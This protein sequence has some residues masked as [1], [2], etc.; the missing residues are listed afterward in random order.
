MKKKRRDILIQI[1][2]SNH[3]VYLLVTLSLLVILAIGVYATTPTNSQDV[4]NATF[5][6]T[7]EEISGISEFLYLNYSTE[8]VKTG[9]TWIDGKPIY[10]KVV[11][12]GNLPASGHK[13]VAHNIAN[14][15]FFLPSSSFA[16]GNGGSFRIGS[17]WSY[18]TNYVYW[19]LTSTEIILGVPPNNPSYSDYHAY[20]ILEYTKTTD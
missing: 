18:S 10:R 3:W 8:E 17:Y 6:H 20:V 5:G 14:L 12:C 11:D 19:F 16:A 9:D 2:L 15:A 7:V 13:R 1:N 4:G